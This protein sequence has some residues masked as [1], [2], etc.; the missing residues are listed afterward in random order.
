M[1]ELRC[2][3][4]R[5]ELF[6]ATELL[7][8]QDP[9][10][11][12]AAQSHP[13]K[14]AQTAVV[15]GRRASQPQNRTHS[16]VASRS[17]QPKATSG[18][19]VDP[20]PAVDPCGAF[21]RDAEELD[22]VPTNPDQWRTGRW[23]TRRGGGGGAVGGVASAASA[24]GGGSGRAVA[25]AVA[26]RAGDRAAAV[27]AADQVAGGSAVGGGSGGGGGGGAEDQAGAVAMAVAM[28]VRR[29][30]GNGGGGSNGGN[31]E[32]NGGGGGGRAVAAAAA[33]VINWVSLR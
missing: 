8:Y 20:Q 15:A 10:D 33:A 3:K 26:A 9:D 32:G 6:R 4:L 2:E 5:P 29:G 1:T 16:R 22:R 27:R 11:A 28:A 13:S 31:G 21:R 24:G 14:V 23:R 25:R 30:G 7:D 17:I 19:V 18:P 12:V